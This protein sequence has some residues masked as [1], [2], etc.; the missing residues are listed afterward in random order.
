MSAVL[1]RA[2]CRQ[3]AGLFFS[4]AS[5]FMEK[6]ER[7][8]IRAAAGERPTGEFIP[9]FVRLLLP[10]TTHRTIDN[11]LSEGDAGFLRPSAFT[12]QSAYKV[13]EAKVRGMLPCAERGLVEIFSI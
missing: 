8:P 7:T 12:K 9:H 11:R 10:Q 4:G 6:L 5:R 1:D 2:R 3:N 13:I